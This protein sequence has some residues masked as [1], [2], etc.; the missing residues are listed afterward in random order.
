MKSS[1]PSMEEMPVDIVGSSTYGRDPKIMASRTFNM[2]IAD[3]WLV[4]FAG[5]KNVLEVLLGGKGRGIFNSTR[6]NK[7][8]VVISN[9]VYAISVYGTS[10][11]QQKQF[12]TLLIG[13]INSFSGD[14]FI[15][16]NNNNQIAI[17]DQHELYIYNYED[18]SFQAAT[19]PDGVIPG[20][21]TYQDGRFIIPDTQ[22]EFW[23]LSQVGDGLNWFW[24]DSDQP[25]NGAIQTKGNFARAVLRV[26]GRGNLLFVFGTTVTELWTAV[27]LTPLPYQK[28]TSMNM[29]YGCVNPA[30]IAESEQIVAWLG[31][32]EKSGPVIM[33]ST[34]SEIQQISTDGINFRFSNLNHPE[35]SAAFF[36]KLS[37][38]LFY[39]LTFYD[40]SDNYTLIY[41]FT[42]QKFFDLT[43]ENMNFHIARKVAFFDND[44]YFISYNDGN[45]YQLDDSF[46]TFDYGNGSVWEIPRVRVTKNI[47]NTGSTRFITNNLT[48][49]IE[50]G[51]D[52]TNTGNDPNY[53][54]RIGLSIS[55]NGGISFGNYATR[56]VYKTGKRMNRLNWWGMGAANDL[57][58]QLRFWGNGPW[59][60]TNG[61]IRVY[62]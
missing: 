1:S 43:D 7:L 31:S 3:D 56:P 57:V 29:D 21:V 34:G 59:K 18:G 13:Q 4:D 10:A 22:S 12:T 36:V 38:H 39:Q 58:L 11:T 23:Y 45:L 60:C 49:P 8:I 24:G 16:D 37:G 48:F 9:N 35:K 51:N 54:P 40:P 62:E 30:T 46:Y 17:C 15:D 6:A 19:L 14:V 2:I 5:Y 27:P 52:T 33:Y 55:R 50:Q 53:N 32:N 41:D 42:E 44:Y 47:R 20:Y 61:V 26:P 28:S 25:V